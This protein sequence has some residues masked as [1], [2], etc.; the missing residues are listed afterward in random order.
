MFHM[1]HERQD[2]MR[3]EYITHPK[4][5]IVYAEGKRA[6]EERTNRA[7]NPYTASNLALSVSWW[8]GW[9]TAE[10][11]SKSEGTLPG[12]DDTPAQMHAS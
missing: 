7:H 10:E 5:E 1:R 8:H 12:Q 9:D 3:N 6:F 2:D 4:R 11:E